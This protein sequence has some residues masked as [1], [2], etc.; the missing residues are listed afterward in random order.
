MFK[1]LTISTGELDA[2]SVAEALVYFGRV[3]VFVRGGTV[4]GLV[5]KFGYEAVRDAMDLGVLDMTFERELYAVHSHKNDRPITHD[6]GN[7][8][9]AKTARGQPINDAADEIEHQ[10][11]VA[12]GSSAETKTRART[13]ASKMGVQNAESKVLEQVRRDIKDGEYLRLA[14]AAWLKALVPEYQPPSE[15]KIEA[16][17]IKGQ[18][19]ILSNLDFHAI[20]AVY[21]RRVPASHSSITAEWFLSHLLDA[22]KELVLSAEGDTDLQVNDGVSAILQQRV[23]TI[24][25]RL[26]KSREDLAYFHTVEF[27]GRTF[28]EAINEG[29]RTG[30]ELIKLLQD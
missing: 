26:N 24:A 1:A 9:L 10:F 29:S 13:L 17:S 4:A 21:N 7:V 30:E 14:A 3:N 23:A 20:S 27:Q 16:A 5:R 19:V 8:S 28:R 2:G 6:F 22:R 15:I 11:V 12:F 18:F 25:K